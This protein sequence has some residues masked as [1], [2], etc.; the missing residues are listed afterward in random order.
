MCTSWH[1]LWPVGH[2]RGPAMGCGSSSPEHALAPSGEL[3]F[4]KKQGKDP[5]LADADIN[6][7]AVD[8]VA[9]FVGVAGALTLAAGA[10]SS[11]ARGGLGT[12]AGAVGSALLGFAKQLPW[13]APIAFVVAGVAQAACDVHALKRDATIFVANVRSAEQIMTKVAAKG[14]LVSV[15]DSCEALQFEMEE[16]L[17]FCHKL[18]TKYFVSQMLT[19]G[20]DCEKFKDLSESISRSLVV[21]AAAASI[22]AH[23]IITNDF[24]QGIALQDK[25]KEL[26]GAAAIAADPEKKAL[27]LEFMKASDALIIS[28]VDE[29]HRAVKLES[30][31]SQKKMDQILEQSRA[32]TKV[33]EDQVA[34]LTKMMEVLL[35]Q[36]VGAA[37]LEVADDGGTTI[38]DALSNGDGDAN[39]NQSEVEKQV[40][41]KMDGAMSSAVVR[42]LMSRMPVGDTEAE[43]I[44]VVGKYGLN[45]EDITDLIGDSDLHALTDL[46][47]AHFGVTNSYVGTID[48][49]RQTCVSFTA[50]GMDNEAA[51]YA[52]D[53]AWFPNI[54]SNCKHVVKKN[55][56]VQANGS[57]AGEME[58]MP[59]LTFDDYAA[60]AQAGHTECARFMPAL[61]AVMADTENLVPDTTLV[62]I[63]GPNP[64]GD[65]GMTYGA[66][67]AFLKVL[68]D[69]GTAGR[70]FPKSR[71][72]VYGPCVNKLVIKRKTRD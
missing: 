38:G 24:E 2:R 31:K 50:G 28:A 69:T 46:A 5:K 18:K 3:P 40:A 52:M 66:V 9:G 6:T 33:L 37:G 10:V 62:P 70:G 27:C 49:N 7:G 16:G 47:V 65:K 4:K 14:K 53:A 68:G 54:V 42:D 22:E 30:R 45:T 63:D 8:A 59:N 19:S 13:V 72:T 71:R 20:R 56:L 39:A 32:S 11:D 64:H 58:A 26:G 55:D 67:R 29:V 43:R 57:F 51:K 48:A 44:E 1:A 34:N 21:I 12:A 36:R 25:I 60:L 61:G 17:A 23:D 15:R 41:Q 35:K